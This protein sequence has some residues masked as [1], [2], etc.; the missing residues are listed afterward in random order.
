MRPGAPRNYSKH[1]LARL[2]RAIR[3]VGGRV[4]DRRTTL[5]REL[6]QWRA[7]LVTDLGGP[8][9]VSTQQAALVDLAV[10]S[11]LATTTAPISGA[12]WGGSK[13]DSGT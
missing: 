8:R 1:G 10:K 11:K 2:K 7:D 12:R 9:A 3:A 6:A 5:G 4:I 13:R